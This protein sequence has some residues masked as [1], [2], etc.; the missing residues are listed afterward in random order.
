[1][2]LWFL[3]I[4]DGEKNETSARRRLAISPK[5]KALPKHTTP[6]SWYC[7]KI[8]SRTK[9]DYTTQNISILLF[10]IKIN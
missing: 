3:Y 2:V 10:S 4:P 9:S 7:K 8:V 1:M 5:T 6:N